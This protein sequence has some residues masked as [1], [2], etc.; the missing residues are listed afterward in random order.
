MQEEQEEREE[1]P[2]IYLDSWAL[3]LSTCVTPPLTPVHVGVLPYRKKHPKK[4]LVSL[5]HVLIPEPLTWTDTHHTHLRLA[6][7]IGWGPCGPG[8]PTFEYTK[9]RGYIAI[10]VGKWVEDVAMG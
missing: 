9:K 10:Q 8:P 5:L 3:T 7:H 2:S 6:E 1:A 4:R